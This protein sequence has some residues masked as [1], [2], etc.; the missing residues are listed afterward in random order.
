MLSRESSISSEMLD[1]IKNGKTIHGVLIIGKSY[2]SFKGKLLYKFIPDCK[3]LPYFMVPYELKASFSKAYK[4]KYAIIAFKEWSSGFMQLA[5]SAPLT[6]QNPIGTLIETIGD[7]DSLDAFCEYQLHR[8]NLVVSMN[9]LTNTVKTILP[10]EE[11]CIQT[12]LQISKYNIQD[13]RNHKHIYTIDP[14]SCTDFDDAFSVSCEDGIA[15]I[16]IYIANVY[17]W[18]ETF[19]L[20]SH[21]TNRVSTI[22]LPD[23][24]RPMLPCMLSDNYCSLKHGCDR[25]VFAYVQR[26]NIETHEPVSESIIQNMLI[27]VKKNC[28]YDDD[29]LKLPGYSLL[30]TLSGHEDSHDVVAYWMI[31]MNVECAKMLASNESNVLNG[32]FRGSESM[33][34]SYSQQ[35]MQHDALNETVYTHITSPIRRLV[36]VLNQIAFA[37]DVSNEATEFYNKWI[38]QIDY[39]N[40]QTTN[41]KRAQMDCDLLAFS[42]NQTDTFK[43]TIVDIIKDGEYCVQLPSRNIVK[44]KS[45]ENYEIGSEYI[46]KILVFND[47][48]TLCKKVRLVIL[49]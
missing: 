12:I 24:K 35:P 40:D 31:K 8:R 6:T 23:K 21:L 5:P 32:V 41:I 18:L 17:I 37:T 19:G 30:K 11:I 3:Q 49:S 27:R 16:T 42:L 44:Y 46:F 39:I 1:F 10:N 2:G 14:E 25:F 33:R 13:C 29:L 20:F 7:V 22:Y 38:N 4:N 36:D 15:T 43:G 26:F 34:A 28:R 47:E 45:T 48:H 9:K